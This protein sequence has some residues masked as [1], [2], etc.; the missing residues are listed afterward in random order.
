MT[1]IHSSKLD[2]ILN[3]LENRRIDM[4]RAYPDIC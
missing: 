2:S 3:L 4:L 1:I